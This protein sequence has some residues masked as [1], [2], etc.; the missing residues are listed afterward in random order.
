MWN[1]VTKWTTSFPP[2][3][4]LK[5]SEFP[6]TSDLPSKEGFALNKDFQNNIAYEGTF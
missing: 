2:D 5:I 1:A 3:L 6:Q 4:L